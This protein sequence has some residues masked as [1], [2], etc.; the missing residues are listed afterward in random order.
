[1][2]EKRLLM[3]TIGN[4]SVGKS[5]FLNSLFGIDF[6]QVQ[7]EITTKFVLFIRHI[8]N[9]NYPKLYKLK[10][11]KN[12]NS[13]NF[14]KDN[15]IIIG[16]NK[17]KEKIQ[18]I[19]TT[20]KSDK[21]LFYMLE[22]EI[23]SIEN[24]TFLKK[25]DFLDIP[26]LNESGI[27]YIQKYFPYI[28]DM[29]KYCLIIFSIENYN[30]KDTLEVLSKVK[31]NINV[32]MENFLI[33]L[34]KID[35]I[36][37]KIEDTMHNFK[38][39]LFDYDGFNYFDN[40]I[41]PMNSI[42]LKSEIQIE[43]NFKHFLN[44]YYIEYNNKE[45][46]LTF[47]EYIKAKLKNIENEKKQIIRNEINNL[48]N[49]DIDKIINIFS[50]YSNEMQSRGNTLMIDF[51]DNN[52][53]KILKMFYI[54]FKKKL[55]ASKNSDYYKQINNYF[56][57]INDY[58]LPSLPMN[59]EINSSNDKIFIDDFKEFKLLNK[60]NDFFK[61]SFSSEQLR[62]FGKIVH[63]LN[64]DFKILYNYIL[65]S[66]LIFIPILGVSNSGKSSFLNC[67]IQKDILTINSSEC[68]RRG[69]IIRYI[70][71]KDNISLYSIKFKSEETLENTYFYYKKNKLLSKNIEQIKEII[72]ITNESFPKNEEDSFFLLECNI[73]FLDDINIESR[74]KKN[75]C[76]IDF[77]GHNTNKNLFFDKNIYQNVVKMSSFFIYLNSGKALKE[78]SNKLLLSKLYLEVINIREGDISPEEYIN[79]CLFIINKVDSLEQDE[80]N[81]NGIQENI[82]EILKI[83]ENFPCN[84]SCSFFSSLLYKKFL[85]KKKEYQIEKI[86]N[87][88]Y[89]K[90]KK[91]EEEIDDDLFGNESEN[92]F[93]KFIINNL[94]KKIKYDYFE[95]NLNDIDSIE[96]S[97]IYEQLTII[98]DRIHTENNIIRDSNYQNNLLIISR[99]L[100]YSQENLLKLNYFKDSYAKETFNEIHNKIIKSFDLKQKEYKNHLDRFFYFMNIFYR[101]ENIFPNNNAKEDFEKV[102]KTVLNNIEK[103]FDNFKGKEIISKYKKQ[104]IN[105]INE[106][107]KDFKF[108]M[109]EN[110]N[111]VDQVIKLLDEKINEKIK[112]FEKEINDELINIENK[113]GDEMKNIGISESSLINKDIT[114]ERSLGMKIFIGFHYCTFGLSTL[115]FCIGGGLFYY[116]PNFLINKFKKERKFNQFIDSNKEYANNLMKSYSNSINKNIKKFKKLSVE[117]AKRLLGL[118]ES[119]NIETDDYWKQTKEQ[120]LNIYDEY[121]KIIK[122]N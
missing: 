88:F 78:D 27:D 64:D 113:I 13:Y 76:F 46:E 5:Y 34:N 58:S 47:L 32:P 83:P 114:Y 23:K 54:C 112:G 37:G 45:N 42:E 51:E 105:Y 80:K 36:N 79:L 6:C 69:I 104:I 60:L 90:F 44:Y 10:P 33:I 29:I 57:K 94:K 62:K 1:M 26:G 72:D 84:I 11:Q 110:E 31:N 98:M 91:Q 102:A 22:I 61:N 92:N 103:I 119:N 3:P 75:I 81:L 82:K 95:T 71:E 30:S 66:K 107:Q 86:I 67:L 16:E 111:N 12:G 40:T 65:N 19:N 20:N 117:N 41:V 121:Q 38:K 15:E 93:L 24:K 9:L 85:E 17:I 63:L 70:E 99:L 2:L 68:T 116:L 73:Q 28:K 100:K 96:S 35:K 74:I 59:N 43:I 106:R 52:D 108:L 21:K 122:L 53:L 55:F 18:A 39:I 7:S 77:P 89:K 14:I 120:Y 109:Q 8:D 56:N 101:I 50:S 4:V 115:L 97:D 118:L 48:N 87:F 49:N 25:F